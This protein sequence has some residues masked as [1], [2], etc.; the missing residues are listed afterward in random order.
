M[1]R[2]LVGLNSQVPGQVSWGEQAWQTSIKTLTPIYLRPIGVMFQQPTL[3]PH[4]TVIEQLL[5]AQNKI[6]RA[7]N[8]LEIMGLQKLHN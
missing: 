1:L 7:K 5:F 6:A 4:Q 8:L 2:A 3:F